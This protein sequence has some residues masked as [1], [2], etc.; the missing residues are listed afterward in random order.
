MLTQLGEWAKLGFFTRTSSGTYALNTPPPQASSITG[1][2]PYYAALRCTAAPTPR[3]GDHSQGFG[4]YEEDPGALGHGRAG[5]C[6]TANPGQ[7]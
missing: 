2:D 4:A 7:G 5:N 6:A 3:P 1:P